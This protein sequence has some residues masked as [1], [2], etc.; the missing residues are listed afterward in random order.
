MAQARSR[1]I[2]EGTSGYFHCVNRCVRRSWLCGLDALSGRSFEHRRAWVEERLLFLAGLFSVSIYAYAVMS[3]HLH[4]VLKLDAET[5]FGWSDHEVADRW[6]RLF[7]CRDDSAPEQIALRIQQIGMDAARVATYRSRLTSL[8][9]FMRCLAE[10]IARRANGED[11]CTGRFWEGRFKAQVLTDE[12]AL[13]AGMVYVDLNPIRAGIA[14]TVGAC[15][16]TGAK[17][18]IQQVRLDKRVAASPLAPLAGLVQEGLGPSVRR[19]LELVSHSGRQWRRQTSGRT[20][21]RVK[22]TL[23]ALK[24]DSARWCQQIAALGHRKIRALGSVESLIVKA[25]AMGQRWLCGIG[26]ARRLAVPRPL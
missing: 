5:G 8:S 20:P 15:E 19:Y 14:A 16:F 12:R 11:D 21:N 25:A 1:M 4:V 2:P 6:C 18:R 3:N 24:L 26:L 10:P 23:A 13:L 22:P 9:W 7:P 17:R